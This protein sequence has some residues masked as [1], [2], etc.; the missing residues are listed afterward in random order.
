MKRPSKTGDEL[1]EVAP[2]LV[3]MTN[4]VL[5]GE[6]WERSD[7]LALR[8]RCMI[9]V[10]A[11]IGANQQLR[12]ESHIN[13]ALNSGVTEEEMGEMMLHLAFYTS[14]PNAIA[15]TRSLY[16]VVQKRKEGQEPD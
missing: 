3:D 10:A 16:N 4:R 6:V 15:A 7:K 14:W 12:L 9:T 2:G 5:Y 1:V 13:F 8:D 11:L